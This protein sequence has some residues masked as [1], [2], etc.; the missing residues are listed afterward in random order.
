[1]YDGIVQNVNCAVSTSKSKSFI[2][3]LYEAEALEI[4]LTAFTKNVLKIEV[5]IALS[6][7]IH[8]M[9][10]TEE[11]VHVK[12]VLWSKTTDVDKL[13]LN[14]LKISHKQIQKYLEFYES[15]I[16]WLLISVYGINK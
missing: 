4:F 16:P 3:H 5:G 6:K 12:D 13:A 9:R 10:S 1:M 2:Y 11:G 15:Q 14:Y 7:D 8:E